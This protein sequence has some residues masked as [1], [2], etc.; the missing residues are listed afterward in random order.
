MSKMVKE[1][2]CSGKDL[3]NFHLI[4]LHGSGLPGDN[5]MVLS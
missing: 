1:S 2:R 3:E 5:A 4:I